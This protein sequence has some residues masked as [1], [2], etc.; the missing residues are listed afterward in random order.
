MDKFYTSTRIFPDSATRF[1]IGAK[2]LFS[3]VP[4]GGNVT[5]ELDRGDGTFTAMQDSP[6]TEDG[7]YHLDLSLARIRITVTGGAG[8]GFVV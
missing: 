1:H 2:A 6:F 8:Y 3:P 4:G 7:H 5:V